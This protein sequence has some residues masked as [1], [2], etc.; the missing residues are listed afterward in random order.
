MSYT[1]GRDKVRDKGHVVKDSRE[2]P[3]SEHRRKDKHHLLVFLSLRLLPSRQYHSRDH[4]ST[5]EDSRHTGQVV[6]LAFRQLPG[7]AV[8][9]QHSIEFEWIFL[10]KQL[11]LYANAHV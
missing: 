1:S 8:D 7:A 9:T 3:M 2:K 11:R 5:T 4:L 10:S 6:S